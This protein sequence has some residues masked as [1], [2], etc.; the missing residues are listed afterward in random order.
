[1]N[2][3]RKLFS[4]FKSTGREAAET[5]IDANAIKIFEQEIYDCETSMTR[6]KHELA[7]VMAEGARLDKEIQQ[8]QSRIEVKEGQAHKALELGEEGLLQEIADHIAEAETNLEEQIKARA[9]IKEQQAQI[10][11]SLK[12]ALQEID[13]YRR[14]LRIVRAKEVTQQTTN[15]LA[16][17]AHSIGSRIVDMRESLDRIKQKQDHFDDLGRS[18]EQ[19]GA[20]FSPNALDRKIQEAGITQSPKRS[21]AVMARIKAKGVCTA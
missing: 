1:M 6:A 9:F 14:E 4:L 8:S 12:K 16:S 19:V 21:E 5:V 17:N 7:K 20:M 10:E 3:H 13:S 11:V 15:A 18:M 2:M